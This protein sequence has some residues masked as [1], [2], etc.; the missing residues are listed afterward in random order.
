MF[1]GFKKCY[2]IIIFFFKSCLS[3][4]QL[5]EEEDQVLDRNLLL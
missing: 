4:S 2:S 1:F 3:F 5:K